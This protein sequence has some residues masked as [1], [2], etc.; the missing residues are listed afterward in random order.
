MLNAEIA[1]LR[2]S[3][4]WIIRLAC[5]IAGC[6]VKVWKAR[7]KRPGEIEVAEGKVK[8]A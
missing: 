3:M 1:G 7:R 4:L 5:R 8:S 6:K 2:P